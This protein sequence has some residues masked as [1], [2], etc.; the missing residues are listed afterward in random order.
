MRLLDAHIKLLRAELDV[1]G[2]E[3]GLIAALV[4][5]A[6]ALA[7]LTGILLYVGGALF[8]G[9]WLFGSMGWGIIHGTLLA[10]ALIGFVGINLAGG[11]ARRYGWGF[12]IGVVAAVVVA[13]LLLSNVGNEG[14]EAGR[15]WLVDQF[16]TEQLPFGEEWLVLLS[17]IVIGAILGL[18]VGLIVAW[19][20]GLTG[21]GRTAA[22]IGLTVLGAIVLAI[23]LPTR[24][25]A[26]D[27]VL[28]LAI[29]I[30]FL[31][32]IVA[33]IA[34]AARAGFDPEARYANLIPRESIAA[35]ESSKAFL[36]E[37]WQ[38]QKERMM[39]R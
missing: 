19:R 25:Q 12:V 31:T 23:W 18:I 29:T 34:L 33:G 11:D 35:F 15:D 13:L 32:W 5:G 1:I 28:G 17:G 27:G 38:R 16:Q 6:L 9:D 37:Q 20:G 2:R 21:S 26:A 36:L 7:F 4:L 3:I 39:G 10:V 22:I 24:Y 14:G 30:G 8:L